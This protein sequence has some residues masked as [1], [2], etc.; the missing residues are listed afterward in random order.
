MMGT[1]PIEA[2]PPGVGCGTGLK[3]AK[4]PTAAKP[5]SAAMERGSRIQGVPGVRAA[6]AVAG[7]TR[8]AATGGRAE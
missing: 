7:V 8:V 5:T 2:A 6:G 3:S 4:A 1:Q